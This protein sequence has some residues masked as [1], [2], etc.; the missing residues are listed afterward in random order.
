MSD[1]IIRMY[2]TAWCGDCKRAK[3]FLGEN[4]VP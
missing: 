4:R 1:G 2:G 3:R